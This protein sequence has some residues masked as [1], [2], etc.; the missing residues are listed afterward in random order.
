MD[1]A[2]RKSVEDRAYALWEEAGRPE[3]SALLFWLR[4]EREMG[5]ITEV[6]A[7]DPFV[8]LH[9]LGEAAQGRPTGEGARSRELLEE[10]VAGAVPRAEQ[11]P[12][13]AAE[14][15]L[16]EHVEHVAEGGKSGPEEG[17]FAGGGEPDPANPRGRP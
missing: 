3:C 11:L 4:A 16:S 2:T 12:E 10:A 1:E 14:N 13:A 9:E 5:L 8:T 7:A 15:P 17:V 6:E